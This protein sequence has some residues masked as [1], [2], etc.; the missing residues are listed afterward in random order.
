MGNSPSNS[1][2]EEDKEHKEVRE[3]ENEM[4]SKKLSHF[5]ECM[6]QLN[7]LRTLKIFSSHYK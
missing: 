4:I 5:S 6:T 1:D 2:D 7:F 3:T